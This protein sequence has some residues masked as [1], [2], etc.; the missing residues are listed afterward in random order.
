MAQKYLE[1]VARVPLPENHREAAS[2]VSKIDEVL[3]GAE[4][5]IHKIDGLEWFEFDA[6]QRTE[7]PEARGPRKARAAE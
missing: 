6:K 3:T 2:L 5:D 4:E 7:R 1:I